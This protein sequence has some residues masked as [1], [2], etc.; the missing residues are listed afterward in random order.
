RRPPDYP[1][2]PN[3]SAVSSRPR[4]ARRG[5]AELVEGPRPYQPH[6]ARLS[7]FTRREAGPALVRLEERRRVGEPQALR[8]LV[9]GS[10]VVEQ[11]ARRKALTHR[12]EQLRVARARLLQ[13][14]AQ[15]ARAHGE[16]P[17]HV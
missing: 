12:V 1:Y 7:N 17:G 14:P 4:A 5:L 15:G 9:D 11:V 16:P 3:C 8:D 2:W 13:A 10:A 6:I